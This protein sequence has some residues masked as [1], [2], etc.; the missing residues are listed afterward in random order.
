MDSILTWN[1]R[2]LNKL[3]KQQEVRK[4]IST[5]NVKLF[6]LLETRVKIPK[7]GILY[8]N[9]C[10]RWCFT[11][12][13]SVTNRGRIVVAWRAEVFTLDV[14]LVT[15]QLI[16]C[17][18]DPVGPHS[19]C[20]CTFVYGYNEK[21]AREVLWKE[22]GG[23]KSDDPWLFMGDFNAVLNLDERIGAPIRLNE[24]QPFRDCGYV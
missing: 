11:T 3:S 5:H 21:S 12:N 17:R 24:V 14:L 9:V 19:W 6:S 2:G 22:L 20:L 13:S 7:M 10:D 1:V 8:L 18:V 4:F 15:A 16:H 23:I